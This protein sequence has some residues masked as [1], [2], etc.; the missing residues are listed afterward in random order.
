MGVDVQTLHRHLAW[1]NKDAADGNLGRV[2]ERRL[3]QSDLFASKCS[4]D[5]AVT[6]WTEPV[7]VEFHEF[8]DPR[9]RPAECADVVGVRILCC[10][11]QEQ[12]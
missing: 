12:R 7:S 11:A 5:A 1:F 3:E 10:R 8:P 9:F 2:L 6:P 4:Q